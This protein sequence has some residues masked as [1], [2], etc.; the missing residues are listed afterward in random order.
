MLIERFQEMETNPIEFV[1]KQTFKRSELNIDPRIAKHWADKGLFTKE[2]DEGA[3]FIFDFIDAFWLKTIV[4][5][6]AYNVSLENIKK[7]RDEF[8][9]TPKTIANEENKQ[10]LIKNLKK[11]KLFSQMNVK[12]LSDE[13][14]WKT[15]FKIEISNF[16][17][18][19]QSILLDRTSYFLITNIEGKSLLV[20]EE[21]DKKELENDQEYKTKF[22]EIT[23]K[24]HLRISL[25]EVLIDLVNTLGNEICLTKIPIL[26]YDEA[27]ILKKVKNEEI[28]SIELEIEKN[29]KTKI[30]TLTEENRE[31]YF[32]LLNEIIISRKYEY[33]VIHTTDLELLSCSKTF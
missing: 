32:K 21:I 24:S 13:E 33:I 16:E 9:N 31:D 14:I 25:N 29:S 1:K 30:I 23:S 3:W 27:E 10:F 8:F 11:S 28:K 26:T 4:K 18:I 17:I 7:I 6:R 22:K 12:H 5:L 15:L 19:L 2:Y 20:K